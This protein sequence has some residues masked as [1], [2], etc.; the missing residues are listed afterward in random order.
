MRAADRAEAQRQ[1]MQPSRRLVA[2]SAFGIGIDKPNIRLSA[3]A[4][5]RTH[6]HMVGLHYQA[7]ARWSSTFRRSGA[8]DAT[9]DRRAAF[10]CSTRPTSTSRSDFRL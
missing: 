8:L 3:A 5:N 6:L 7:P 4:F 2:T 10:S 1:F 9:G